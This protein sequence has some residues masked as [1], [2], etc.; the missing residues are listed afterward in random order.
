MVKQTH[1]ISFFGRLGECSIKQFGLRDLAE[2]APSTTI[3]IVGVFEY[4]AFSNSGF[5]QYR[6]RGHRF[7][8]PIR[9]RFIFKKQ[10]VDFFVKIHES[11]TMKSES[12]RNVSDLRP[13][14]KFGRR[15]G[16]FIS[17]LAVHVSMC[18]ITYIDSE[19]RISK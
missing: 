19:I 18:Q 17:N 8:Y 16:S 6:I 9:Q 7:I 11:K 2:N 12:R 3:R 15:F 10:F 13:Y 14:Y 1:I 4:M 5:A